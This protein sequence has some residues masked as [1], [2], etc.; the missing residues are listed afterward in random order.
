MYSSKFQEIVFSSENLTLESSWLP[1]TDEMTGEEY[2]KEM[3]AQ[4]DSVV[5]CKP[6]KSL[7]NTQNLRFPIDPELQ[8]W[9]N[10]N[11]LYPLSQVPSLKKVALVVSEEMITALGVE[12]ALEQEHGD[13][14]N[15]Q[16]F[17][18]KEEARMWLK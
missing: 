5:N 18:S 16:Y 10:I 17:A 13:A 9:T 4:L 6:V 7:V 12:Q 2:K 14:F 8:E 15:L 11:F 3:L 1:T